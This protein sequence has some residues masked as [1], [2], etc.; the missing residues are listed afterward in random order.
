MR[1]EELVVAF[2]VALASGAWVMWSDG[3]EQVQVVLE[4][5]WG[6]SAVAVMMI[7]GWGSFLFAK[8]PREAKVRGMVLGMVTALIVAAVLF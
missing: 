4:N 6:R 3:L 2:G 7:I 5:R 8:N 1:R